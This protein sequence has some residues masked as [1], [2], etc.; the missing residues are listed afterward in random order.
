LNQPGTYLLRLT[1]SDSELTSSSDVTITISA[2]Q[3]PVVSAG[4]SQQVTFPGT[5]NLKGAATDD[6]LPAGSTLSTFWEKVS[7]PGKVTFTAPSVSP[8]DDFSATANP[9]GAWTY[10]FTPTRGGAFTAY[11]FTGQIAGMPAWFRTSPASGTTFPLLTFNNAGAPVVVSGNVTTP[12]NTFLLHPGSAGENSVLRWTAPNDGTFLVQGRFFGLDST[13]TDV[14][15]LLNSSAMVLSG[16]I[17]IRNAGVP[18]TF[19]KTLKAGDKLDFSV[20]FGNGNFNSDST[21]LTLSITSAGSTSS[22]ASFSAPGDYVLRFIGS[23]SELFSF[24]DTHVHVATS[25]VAAPNGLVG[26]WPGDGDARDL[27]SGN[28]GVIED[29]LT[30]VPGMVGKAFGLNGTAADVVVNA[31]A[32]LN[33]KSFTLAAWVFPLDLG[34]ARPIL[35]FSSPSTQGMH[36]WENLNSSVQVSPGSVYVNLVDSN[37]GSHI[38]ATNFGILQHHQWNHVALTY[39]QTT[40]TARIYVN[41]SAVTVANLGI[42]TPRTSVPLNI[43]SRPNST[44]FL[45]NIDEVGV[46]NQA[47]SPS[48]IQAIYAAAGAGICKPTGPQPPVVSAGLNQTISLPTTQ[49][50]LNGSA[51]DPDG[52]QL[53]ISWSVTS[54]TGN[55]VFGNTASPTTTATFSAPGVYVLRLTASNNQSTAF[56]EVTVTLLQPINK[57]PQVSAG[58]D[59]CSR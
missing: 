11:S 59:Y 58:T 42:F 25:C 17:S 45:G 38:F 5:A 27:A 41:G 20:G 6:G 9:S 28:T 24:S 7:G 12:A 13:T 53:S 54:G 3:A 34:T 18:F 31:S 29:G 2:N 43:G 4:D 26:W 56:S 44:R 19:V 22:T 51:T 30:F 32:A 21:G 46:F 23:D 57:A 36:M 47:L 16:N 14:A 52:G 1:A 37:G 10:G 33:V 49:V 35:E 55:V 8:A 50:T 39:D 48:D 40:G 15:V